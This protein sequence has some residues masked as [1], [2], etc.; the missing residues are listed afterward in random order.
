MWDTIRHFCK[1]CLIDVVH[2]YSYPS[3][4]FDENYTL[5][6]FVETILWVN[7]MVKVR[8]YTT[9]LLN[10]IFYGFADLL[11]SIYMGL[12]AS[13][14]RFLRAL[15]VPAPCSPFESHNRWYQKLCET[16]GYLDMVPVIG[17]AESVGTIHYKHYE[18]SLLKK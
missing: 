4:Q 5:V 10:S 12:P 2:H 16:S 9:G 1:K 7:W 11:D 17:S 8:V 13:W 6:Q 15:E 14:I 18:G 3:A